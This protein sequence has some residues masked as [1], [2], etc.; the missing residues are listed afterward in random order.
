MI[1]KNSILMITDVKNYT[2]EYSGNNDSKGT[3][4]EDNNDSYNINNSDSSDI[5]SGYE[6]NVDEEEVTHGGAENI[7]RAFDV[8]LSARSNLENPTRSA[9]YIGQSKR[10]QRRQN[11]AFRRAAFGTKPL[12]AYFIKQVS[13]HEQEG[14]EDLQQD[15][16]TESSESNNNTSNWTDPKLSASIEKLKEMK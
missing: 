10:T 3:N 14:E 5:G 13:E 2:E 6:T 4:N 16:S 1:K 11:A 9:R 8:A 15:D 7:E 12:T